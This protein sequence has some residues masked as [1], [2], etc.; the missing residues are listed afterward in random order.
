[1]ST[2]DLL[3]VVAAVL[4]AMALA[5]ACVVLFAAAR[6]MER[7]AR[8][9]AVSVAEFRS[10]AEPLAQDL[11]ASAAQ[12][13]GEVQRVEHLLDLSTGIAERVDATTGA[14][15]RAITTPVIKGAAIAEG[16]RR[17]ARRLGPRRGPSGRSG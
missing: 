2:G 11:A 3:L 4:G 5:V 16:T 6:R 10:T 14:T 17:A 12:A 1:M 13:S 8:D 7:A 9:L 15:Y